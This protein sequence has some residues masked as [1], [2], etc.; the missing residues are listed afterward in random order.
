MGSSCHDRAAPAKQRQLP[1]AAFSPGTHVEAREQRGH[2]GGASA[3]Q[4]AALCCC[5]QQV[6]VDAVVSGL[7]AGKTGGGMHHKECS[8]G[9]REVGGKAPVE[10]ADRGS[11]P[12][13]VLRTE[14]RHCR[15]ARSKMPSMQGE[16]QPYAQS[17]LQVCRLI[18]GP[19]ERAP[20]LVA[21]AAYQQA[22]CALPAHPAS[23]T[24]TPA[25][26]RLAAADCRCCRAAFLCSASVCRRVSAAARSCFLASPL[27]SQSLG[28]M[29]CGNW[30]TSSEHPSLHC[31]H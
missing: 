31:C 14:G 21:G 28:R 13:H 1:C 9:Q 6:R 17:G 15:T 16:P 5:G 7:Q 27:P 25:R 30:R 24:P 20:G 3:A 26:T 11:S 10:K 2:G 18:R 8:R 23:A 12:A 22:C 4:D 29:Y 19:D